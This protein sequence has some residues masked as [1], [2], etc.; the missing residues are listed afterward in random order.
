[1]R[2]IT[3]F[4]SLLLCLT[5]ALCPGRALGEKNKFEKRFIRVAKDRPRMSYWVYRPPETQG[6][7]LPLVVYLH[8]SGE[9]GERALSGSLPALVNSSEPEAKV[10]APPAVYLVPQLPQD[11]RWSVLEDQ[12]V[13]MIRQE[14]A[15]QQADE[16]RVTLV[17]FS[18]GGNY[19]WELASRHPGLFGR[20]V[21]VCG[22]VEETVEAEAFAGVR[23]RSYVG[24]KDTHVPPGTAIAFV[25]QLQELGFD[26]DVRE[27]DGSH[28]Q[29]QRWVLQDQ[30]IID[31][32]AWAEE[33]GE[34]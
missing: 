17:G 26:A 3:L 29:T 31:W 23:V 12:I 4:L 33:T 25:E 16:A 9:R 24:L 22:R 21:S 1:M 18:L 20:M 11:M 14:L 6:Q 27:Y 2:K 15:Q 19:A 13:A 7:R 5:A 34:E 32:I 10:I 30:G 28:A 8:G